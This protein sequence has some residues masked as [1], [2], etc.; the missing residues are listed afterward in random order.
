MSFN[1]EIFHFWEYFWLFQTIRIAT[2][3]TKSIM[4]R[5]SS[6]TKKTKDGDTAAG[7]QV[8]GYGGQVVGID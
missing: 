8:S 4:L 3:G 5:L 1:E 6:L 7:S 2:L